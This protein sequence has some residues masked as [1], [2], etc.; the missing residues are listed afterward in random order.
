MMDKCDTAVRVA[1]FKGNVYFLQTLHW[2]YTLHTHHILTTRL[3][4]ALR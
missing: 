3:C 2:S 1:K 4:S